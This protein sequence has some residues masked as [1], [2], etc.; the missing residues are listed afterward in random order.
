[1]LNADRIEYKKYF[2]LFAVL[3]LAVNLLIFSDTSDGAQILIFTVSF[4][5]ALSFF[6]VFVGNKV[7][8]S[9]SR[10]LTLPASGIEKF[11]ELLIVWFIYLCIFFMIHI[12]VLGIA[13]LFNDMQIWFT[14]DFYLNANSNSSIF[15]II[16][17]A[18]GVILFICTFL[19]MCSIA[20]RKYALPLGILF[21]IL[22]SMVY[23]FTFG[24]LFLIE[25]FDSIQNFNGFLTSNASVETMLFLAEYN[26]WGLGIASVVLLFISYLKIKEKRIR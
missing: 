4:I 12:A 2:I 1:M 10:F 21:L 9:K 11:V 22:C 17:K 6:Y 14:K 23:S 3:I 13:S 7:N 20:I 25:G 8:R 26:L 16:N 15:A 5:F 24:I 18:L 19:F